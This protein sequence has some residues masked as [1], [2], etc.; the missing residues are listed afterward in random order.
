MKD[1]KNIMIGLA[2]YD[3]VLGLDS[4]NKIYIQ[5]NKKLI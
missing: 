2:D 3:K 5:K 1:L 4:R